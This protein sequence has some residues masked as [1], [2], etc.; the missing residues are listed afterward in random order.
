MERRMQI[1]VECPLC[2]WRHFLEAEIEEWP[3]K[4]PARK[5]IENQLAVWISSQCPD[6]L[7]PILEMSKN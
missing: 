4:S 3:L 5:E 2:H 6:H 7:G 1:P